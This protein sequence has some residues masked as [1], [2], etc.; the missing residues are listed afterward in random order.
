MSIADPDGLRWT[1]SY[2]GSG[3]LTTT[4][5]PAGRQTSA[6]ALWMSSSR[7]FNDP[8][9]LDHSRFLSQKCH[10]SLR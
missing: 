2:D 5:D 1:L 3:Q 8:K 9:P 7:H 10:P 6:A 4:T